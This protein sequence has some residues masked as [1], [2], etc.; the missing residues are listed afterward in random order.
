MK[1]FRFFFIEKNAIY[2]HNLLYTYII[3]YIGEPYIFLWILYVQFTKD[4]YLGGVLIH[5]QMP[6]D[7][8]RRIFS[9]ETRKQ[10]TFKH[11]KGSKTFGKWYKS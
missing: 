2:S 5:S 6:E 1:L 10:M 9:L 3:Y 7:F 8:H 11:P 4:T